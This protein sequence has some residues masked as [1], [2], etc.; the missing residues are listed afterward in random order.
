MKKKLIILISVIMIAFVFFGGMI[1]IFPEELCQTFIALE[2]KRADLGSFSVSADNIEYK[3]LKGGEGPPLV[4]LHGFGANKDNWITM[5]RYLTPHFT[6]IAPDLPGF[7][8]SSKIVDLDYSVTTQ[9]VRLD[10]FLSA[11][12]LT[13]IHI[14]GNS[15]GGTIAAAYAFQFKEKVK[16]MWLIAPGGVRSA[17]ESFFQKQMRLGNNFMIIKDYES[18][19]TMLENSFA[20]PPFLLSLVKNVYAEKSIQDL[21]LYKKIINDIF[22]ETIP[23]EQ[24]LDGVKLPSLIMWGDKDRILDVS[25]AAILC[26]SLVNSSC[27]IIKKAGHVPMIEKP[28]ITADAFLKFSGVVK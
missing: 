4:L 24:V 19:N 23:L 3:Y 18:Y 5:A 28:E 14:G 1:L 25:G 11:I 6:V 12:G 16:S 27:V 26:Q 22:S 10:D 21:E 13:D 17:K 20:R 15:M 8:E 7:G 9:A 2:R